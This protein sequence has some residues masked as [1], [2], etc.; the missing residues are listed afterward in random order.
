MSAI[1]AAP[2]ALPP[3]NKPNLN[4]APKFRFQESADNITKH[5]SMVEDRTF[6]RAID[7]ALMQY[8]LQ[9]A[10]EVLDNPQLASVAGYKNAGAVEF[11]NVLKNL[12]ETPQ[13]IRQDQPVNLNHN[14]SR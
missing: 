4:P 6:Q 13:L 3:T 9:V 12:S 14:I 11:V 10:R 5:R 7:F 1:A 8:Q 2:T